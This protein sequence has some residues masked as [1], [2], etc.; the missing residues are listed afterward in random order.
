MHRAL[1]PARE[2]LSILLRKARFG[3][4]HPRPLASE[5]ADLTNKAAER[6]IIAGDLAGATGP[7]KFVRQVSFARAFSFRNKT[8]ALSSTIKLN[9]GYDGLCPKWTSKDR[10]T[11]AGTRD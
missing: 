10:V 5:T 7:G 2:L 1:L 8:R 6:N 3:A 9:R 4:F 11:S